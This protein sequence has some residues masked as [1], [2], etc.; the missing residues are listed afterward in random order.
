MRKE[1]VF[2]SLPR[3]QYVVAAT[4]ESLDVAGPKVPVATT[5]VP[6][7]RCGKAH[8][9]G[10]TRTHGRA[11]SLYRIRITVPGRHTYVMLPSLFVLVNG[12]FLDYEYWCERQ[13]NPLLGEEHKL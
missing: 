5:T 4:G 1:D 2:Q 6:Q 12:V 3:Q 13:E 9:V 11:F 7:Q 8:R 10:S